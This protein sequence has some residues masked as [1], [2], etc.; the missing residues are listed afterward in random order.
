[1][2]K[3]LKGSDDNCF[4]SIV[5]SENGKIILEHIIEQVLRK[6]I[7]IIE[8]INTEIGKTVDKEKIKRLDVLVKI[9]GM[10]ANIEVNTNDY[11]Y[12]KFFRNFAYLVALFNRYNIKTDENN[13]KIYDLVTDIIQINLNFGP[14]DTDELIIENRFGN[15][16][17]WI[18]ENLASYDVFI[19]NIKKFCYDKSELEKYKYLLML[20]MTLEELASFYPD[21]EIIKEYGDALVKYSED[22]FIYPYS[23]EEEKEILHN[24]LVK[25]AEDKGYKEGVE[26]GIEQGIE[27]GK[28]S[29]IKN[30]YKIGTSVEDIS[31]A[32]NLSDEKIKKIIN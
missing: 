6:K 1:M 15:N 21:D 16:K 10:L 24:T 7:E 22:T 17:G 4:K 18:I 25:M 19:D 14:S 20:D 29:I 9:D 27:Q 26:Q 28:I 12:A 3:T 8:F 30:F 23:E 11:N 5:H 32:T 31:K 13:K 2:S